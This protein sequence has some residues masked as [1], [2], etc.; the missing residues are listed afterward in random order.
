MPPRR[1]I[2]SRRVATTATSTT[3]AAREEETAGE[4]T[5]N[6]LSVSTDT[7]LLTLLTELHDE[8][9]NY[10]TAT[11]DPTAVDPAMLAQWRTRVRAFANR[12]ATTQ[13]L[14]PAL[15]PF[16]Q[17]G[18]TVQEL[19]TLRDILHRTLT[20]RLDIPSVQ[21]RLL[22]LLQEGETSARTRERVSRN[23]AVETIVQQSTTTTNQSADDVRQRLSHL[24]T[25]DVLLVAAVRQLVAQQTREGEMH[26]RMQ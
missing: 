15:R 18:S 3:A 8:I 26:F 24:T 10:L 1:P 22:T 21:S 13:F 19:T 25:S 17:V 2:R 11:T 7:L 5:A 20:T 16:L 14:F 12:S 6:D 4:V 9:R 23:Q